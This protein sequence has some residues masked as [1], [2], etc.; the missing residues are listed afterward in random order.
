MVPSLKLSQPSGLPVLTVGLLLAL[1]AGCGP[2]AAERVEQARSRYQAEVNGWVVDQ[3]PS[4]MPPRQSVLL[5]IVV[6]HDSAEKLP[7]IT[8]DLTQSGADRKEKRRWKVWVDTSSL[9][10]GPG[11]QVSHPLRDADV[12]PGDR[13]RVEVRHP[14]PA[15]ERG[16]YKELS[17]VS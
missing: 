13:F 14:V 1:L 9:E 2:S 4:T 16:E 10:P 11:T 8:L 5:D 7:G 3:D 15:E 12:Q 17:G 6:H